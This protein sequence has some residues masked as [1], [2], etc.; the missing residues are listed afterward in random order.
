MKKIIAIM[1][2]G[3]LLVSMIFINGCTAP[4]E[5][6]KPKNDNEASNALSDMGSDIKGI[7]GTL[8]EIDQNFGQ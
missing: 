8:D 5:D 2:V 6:D 4:A 1:F 7:G 3:L